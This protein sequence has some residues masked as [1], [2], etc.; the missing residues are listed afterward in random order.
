MLFASCLKIITGTAP[1]TG[2]H[3]G[4]PFRHSSDRG[5]EAQL[6]RD[7]IAK[8]YVDEILG[9]AQNKHYQLACTRHFEVTHPEN[10]EKIDPIEHPNQYYELSKNLVVNEEQ[11]KHSTEEA[12]EIDG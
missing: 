7:N 9:L 10:K 6:Y 11:N 3:H 5:L 2:E 4:C 12:M 8:P 1:G